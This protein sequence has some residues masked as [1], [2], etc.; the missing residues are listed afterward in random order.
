[1]RVAF[2]G[3]SDLRIGA[4]ERVARLGDADL[5]GIDRNGRLLIRRAPGQPTSL[6]LVQQ[7]TRELKTILGPTPTFIPR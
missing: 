3:G 7:W 2:D 6:I 1:M 4:P 5:V